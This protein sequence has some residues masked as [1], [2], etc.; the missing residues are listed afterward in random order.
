MNSVE[1][2]HSGSGKVIAQLLRQN[3]SNWVV[4]CDHSVFFSD[5]LGCLALHR[6]TWDAHYTGGHGTRNLAPGGRP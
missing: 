3:G 6:W 2:D 5:D 1:Q 4:D